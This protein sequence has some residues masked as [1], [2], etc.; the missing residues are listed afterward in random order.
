MELSERMQRVDNLSIEELEQE[1][2]L[3]DE[4]L[5][6]DLK[7]AENYLKSL[8]FNE[9]I[10]H[11][12]YF[13]ERM[14]KAYPISD[15]LGKLPFSPFRD[16]AKYIKDWRRGVFV[17]IANRVESVQKKAR[18]VRFFETPSYEMSLFPELGI[19]DSDYEKSYGV[20][21]PLTI[22]FLNDNAFQ[23][24][25]EI[26]TWKTP[27]T[28]DALSKIRKKVLLDLYE[29]M[30]QKELD[31]YCHEKNDTSLT[32]DSLPKKKVEQAAKYAIS[33][34]ASLFIKDFTEKN[35]INRFVF[36]EEAGKIIK[37]SKN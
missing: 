9:R 29:E 12:T 10:S 28:E 3:L 27:E 37:N 22:T 30:L 15:K 2:S 4:E 33:C 1:L 25:M 32:L 23:A 11:T 19:S 26:I 36:N 14:L 18:K 24:F 34:Y 8:G 17:Y 20:T 13:V 35:I 7:N 6:E 16:I 21:Y 5:N 31:R